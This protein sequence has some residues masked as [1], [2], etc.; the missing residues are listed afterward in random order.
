MEED[1]AEGMAGGRGGTVDRLVVGLRDGILNNRY[2][3]GQRLIEADLTRD[4]GVSRGPLREAFR[5]LSAEGLLEIVPNRGALVRRLTYVETIEL[6]QIR[7]ALEALA[8]RL[9]AAAID[10]D[11]NA[12]RFEAAIERIWE[13]VP[14]T[15]GA[16]YH[17]E[18][19]QFHHAILD[20]CGNAQ[21]A[22]LSRQLQLPLIMLQLS[23]AMNPDMYQASVKEHRAIAR[24]I[25]AGDPDAAE[26]R[27]R[28]HLGR[29]LEIA[30][31]MPESIFRR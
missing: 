29:A 16:V 2:A 25:L 11:G 22:A 13:D 8:V 14:R 21:L 1:V 27:M 3:P 24:A 30:A 19:W 5:R 28:G 20:V 10:T 12:A 6:F 18:N 26:A 17:E 23:G 9:A 4:F 7:T 15:N 31:A